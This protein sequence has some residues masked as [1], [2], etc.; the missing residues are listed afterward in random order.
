M[1]PSLEVYSKYLPHDKVEAR[2]I[3]MRMMSLFINTN[4]QLSQIS[5]KIALKNLQTDLDK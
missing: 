2:H 4:V 1:D 5:S 3:I